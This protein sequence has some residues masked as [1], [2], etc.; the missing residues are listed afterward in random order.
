MVETPLNSCLT[1]DC[2][3]RICL[4]SKSDMGEEVQKTRFRSHNSPAADDANILFEFETD[5]IE[6]VRRCAKSLLK[7]VQYRKI[8]EVYEIELSIIKEIVKKLLYHHEEGL[9]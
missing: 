3:K 8:K 1:P 7:P 9:N 6:E 2:A 5:N 4:L